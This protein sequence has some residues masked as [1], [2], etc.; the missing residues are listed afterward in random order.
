MKIDYKIVKNGLQDIPKNNGDY[1]GVAVKSYNKTPIEEYIKSIEESYLP[2]LS[3]QAWGTKFY[4]KELVVYHKPKSKYK[5]LI[6]Q[7]D[8]LHEN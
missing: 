2:L 6:F 5:W 4:T 8:I 7:I 1:I 3:K